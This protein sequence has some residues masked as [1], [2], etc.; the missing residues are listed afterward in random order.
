M[1]DVRR[2]IREN[3]D[4]AGVHTG[5]LILVACSGGADSMALAM[6]AK[7]EGDRAGIR[8]GAVIVD[9]QIQAATKAVAAA[10]AAKLTE[11]GLEPVSVRAVEVPS[12]GEGGLEAAARNARYQALSEAA[13]QTGAKFVLLGH[14]L[15]DQAET[16]LLGLTRGSGPK[17]VAGMRAKNDIWLRPL[18]GIR[19]AETEAFCQDSGIEFWNDPHN[20]DE[21]FTRVRIRN[22]VL[23]MLEEQLGPGIA[24]ALS[25]T[26]EIL[27]EDIDYLDSLALAE[28][29]RIA[30]S[31]PTSIELP[32]TDLEALPKVIRVRVYQRVLEVFAA[33]NS[34]THLVAIDELIENWHGQ[35]E[36]TLP[37]VRVIRQVD[38][39]S[40]KT[41]K[42]LNPG[43]C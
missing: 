40:F 6:A 23:P 30:K 35:K 5:D 28:H 43:A 18:L 13:S 24:E 32:I 16:V 9:H 38:K 4:A 37:G 27:T 41:T 3:W 25:R 10:T 14:T 7:F 8:V 22:S 17:S 2:A 11:N 29:K 34:R 1:A 20:Q 42:T 33:N 12:A 19:R 15:D 26:G 31:G 36:L 21:K 39:I